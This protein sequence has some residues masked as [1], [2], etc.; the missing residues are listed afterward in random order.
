MV[1]VVAG[2][3]EVPNISRVGASPQVLK[4]PRRPVDAREVEHGLVPVRQPVGARLRA[5][6]GLR[7]HDAV[8]DVPPGFARRHLEAR[9]DAGEKSIPVGVAQV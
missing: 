1:A 6:V 7:P 5:T 4:V 9:G 2:A 8:G 3:L